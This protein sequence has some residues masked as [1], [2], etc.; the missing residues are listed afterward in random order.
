[1]GCYRTHIFRQIKS[2]L[3]WLCNSRDHMYRQDKKCLFL[4]HLLFRKS[5]WL[6]SMWPELSNMFAEFLGLKL[7][8]FNLKKFL[9]LLWALFLSVYSV[10]HVPPFFLT[11]PFLVL[12]PALIIVVNNLQCIVPS[13]MLV[14][15][16]PYPLS[17]IF[18]HSV[19]GGTLSFIWPK[20]YTSNR[21]RIF[22][23]SPSG[24]M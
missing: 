10:F 5:W 7:E 2:Y 24:D 3:Y 1:M 11:F 23:I 18:K 13:D 8:D 20:A 14:N 19:I 17:Y 15:L 9:N 12:L 21:L 4:D 22:L 16:F 6:P